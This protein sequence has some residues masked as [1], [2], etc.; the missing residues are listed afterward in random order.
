VGR[1]TAKSAWAALKYQVPRNCGT[2]SAGGSVLC[3]KRVC[4]RAGS[5][6]TAT[7]LCQNSGKCV[8]EIRAT[9]QVID[10]YSWR[11]LRVQ[12]Q[13]AGNGSNGELPVL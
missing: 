6:L 11:V 12:E 5:R 2:S 4:E 8:Q 9:S 1:A 3:Q 7:G 10:N 13:V